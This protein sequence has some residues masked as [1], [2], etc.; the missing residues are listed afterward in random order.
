MGALF[1]LRAHC[2]LGSCLQ[3]PPAPPAPN[4]RPVANAG[5]NQQVEIGSRVTLSGAESSDPE[6]SALT[7]LW[8]QADSDPKQVVINPDNQVRFQFIPNTAGTYTFVLVVDDG[9]VTSLPDTV[10]VTAI[11]SD[12]RAPI[13][14]AGPD[15]IVGTGANVPLSGINSSDP[16][17]DDLTYSWAVIAAPDSVQIADSTAVQTY[18]V[19]IAAGEYRFRLRVSD[20]G[21]SAEDEVSILVRA[22]SNLPPTAEAG[23]DQQVAQGSIVE[24]DGSGSS[25]PDGDSFELIYHWS[26]GRVPGGNVTL[27]DST[28]MRPSFL[29][30]SPASTFSAFRYP[31]A[32]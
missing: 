11:S 25:D 22:T 28:A 2:N 14:N 21:L 23:Q 31:M 30:N 8:N 15:L 7:Y 27:S 3:R 16:N 17:G 9:E 20:G 6:G 29:P 18:F 19:A 10:L 5:Q 32:N 26:V 13:A 24:L 12:N 1:T 4:E